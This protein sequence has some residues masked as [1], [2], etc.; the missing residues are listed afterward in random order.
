VVTPLKQFR[1][2][3]GNKSRRMQPFTLPSA[4]P[5]FATP[6]KLKKSDYWGTTIIGTE[7]WNKFITLAKKL[8][9]LLF[10]YLFHY[11]S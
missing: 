11:L 9:Q 1:F 2:E 7:N 3:H 6:Q 10:N 5:V 8:L 4:A